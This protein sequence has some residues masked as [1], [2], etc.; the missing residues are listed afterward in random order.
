MTWTSIGLYNASHVTSELLLALQY[1]LEP[2]FSNLITVT[3]IEPNNNEILYII[4]CAGGFS[5]D[6]PSTWPKYYI[7][8]QLEPTYVFERV[9]YR[10][11]LAGA[12]RNW[13]YSQKN[14]DY[15]SQYPEIRIQYLPIGYVP[16]I[17]AVTDYCDNYKDI[18]VL[19][20]GWDAHSYRKHIRQEMVQAGL[21]IVFICGLNLTGMQDH[22]RR[23]KIC[24]NMRSG[25][26]IQC[27]ETVRLNILLSNRAC[28]VNEEIND[29]ELDLYNEYLITV[30]YR[31]LTQAC[32]NLIGDFNQRHLMATKSFNWYS[33]QR[34]WNDI[35]DFK[36]L[37]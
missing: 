2:L 10:A 6:N 35:V 14:V 22:I 3:S 8:Y 34:K 19:L 26:I 31:R 25:I 13:D 7:T 12:L 28:I 20:L 17:T 37:I 27:L 24:L 30:P 1:T 32:L 21:K 5:Y 4:I 11:F 9:N 16:Q 29:P 18:D 33:T 15:L 36:Q 23:A